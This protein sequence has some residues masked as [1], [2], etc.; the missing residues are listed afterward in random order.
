VDELWQ[1]YITCHQRE[2]ITVLKLPN[3]APGWVGN[4][5][6]DDEGSKSDVLKKVLK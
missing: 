4:V 2:F 6:D 3:L 1:H 5:E